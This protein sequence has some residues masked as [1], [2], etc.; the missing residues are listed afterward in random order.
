[1]DSHG[2]NRLGDIQLDDLVSQQTHRPSIVERQSDVDISDIQKS[3][4]LGVDLSGAG[5]R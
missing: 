5:L 1:L 2:G 4:R 3:T